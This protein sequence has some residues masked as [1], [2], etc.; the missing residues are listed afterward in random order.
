MREM[1]ATM[2]RMDNTLTEIK[3]MLQATLP[4]LATEVDLAQ[5]RGELTTELRTGLASKPSKTH[6]WGI[7][8]ALIVAYAAGLAA[9][10]IL[11]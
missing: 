5:L 2:S 10:A 8:T 3:A 4:H 7:M 1:R 11:K 6:M 9:L